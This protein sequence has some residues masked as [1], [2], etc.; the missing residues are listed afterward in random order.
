MTWLVAFVAALSVT[1]CGPLGTRATVSEG[2]YAAYR[3]YALAPSLE[4][5]LAASYDYLRAHPRGA[6]HAEIAAWFSRTSADY[7]Q[8]SWGDAPHLRKF[9]TAVPQGPE[10]SRAAARL[11]ELELTAAYRKGRERAFDTKVERLETRL[12][13][14][15]AGRRRLV[16]DL[17]TWIRRLAAIRTW[18]APKSELD[19]ELIFAYRLSEPEARCDEAACDKTL[20]VDY[21]VPE[22]HAESDRQAVYDVGLRLERGGVRAAWIS[23]PDLFT[24]LGEA[25]SVRAVDSAD[26]VAR[27]EAIG[28][29]TQVIALAVEPVLPARRCAA[30]AVSPVVLR[31]VC[32][33]VSL[34]VVSAVEL[35]EED[36]VVVEPDP[37]S[38]ITREP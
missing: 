26:W 13:V 29:A 27:A 17:T 12:A 25:V 30:D 28:N 15:E 3:R 5:K 22:G 23:G 2:E 18:G 21:A 10:A 38:G 37:G 31:R 16:T 36:R 8:R 1:S 35:G 19:H 20:V 6:Y 4:Q 32:D 7:V 9:L 24:R 33:G 14:A 11:V 34:S